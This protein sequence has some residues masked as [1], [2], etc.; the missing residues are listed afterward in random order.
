[1][2]I[3]DFIKGQFIDVIEWVDT[4]TDAMVW[5]FERKG[6][7]IKIIGLIIF[8]RATESLRIRLRR[9]KPENSANEIITL[10]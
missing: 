1:M 4:T 3:M 10:E 6:N 7:E 5:K 8:F 9:Y 2:G